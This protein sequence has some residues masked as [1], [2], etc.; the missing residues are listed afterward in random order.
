[1]I[2]EPSLNHKKCLTHDPPLRWWRGGGGHLF[3]LE[4][5]RPHLKCHLMCSRHSATSSG[6]DFTHRLPIF[7]KEARSAPSAH[8]LLVKSCHHGIFGKQGSNDPRAK[9]ETQ[10]MPHSRP[11]NHTKLCPGQSSELC[12]KRRRVWLCHQRPENAISIDSSQS[13]MLAVCKRTN[14]GSSRTSLC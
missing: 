2:Q 5:R 3:S 14:F 13:K 10:K 9:F 8:C 4:K 11:L 7:A 1:M 12:T 6:H